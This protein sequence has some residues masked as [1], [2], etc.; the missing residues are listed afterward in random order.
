MPIYLAARYRPGGIYLGARCIMLLH[1]LAHQGVYPPGTFELLGLPGSWYEALEWQYPPEQRQGA[2]EEEGRA[3]NTLKGAITTADRIV[4]VSPGAP[5]PALPL[6]P[7]HRVLWPANKATNSSIPCLALEQP[8]AQHGGYGA[9]LPLVSL[10]EIQKMVLSNRFS[11]C[12]RGPLVW[13]H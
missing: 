7:S 3:I 1:N 8:C 11:L 13:C 12:I 4:A 10:I 2:Y 6:S 5:P 9:V